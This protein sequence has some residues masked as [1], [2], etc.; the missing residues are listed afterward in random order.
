MKISRHRRFRKNFKL[1]I[2]N[3]PKLV[4]KFE[5]RLN[6]FIVDPKNPLLKDHQLTGKMNIYRSFSLTGDIR[7]V[8]KIEGKAIE[9]YDIGTHNQVYK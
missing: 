4:K 9:L 8:Y 5:E 2:V 3:N 6:L 7:V 1:R